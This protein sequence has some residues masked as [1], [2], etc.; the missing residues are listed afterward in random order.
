M[1]DK[2]DNTV[3]P[4]AEPEVDL[5]LNTDFPRTHGDSTRRLA[6]AMQRYA[7]WPAIGVAVIGIAVCTVLFGPHGG[8]AALIGGLVACGSSLGTLWLMRRAADLSPQVAMVVALGGFVGKLV[9]LMIVMLVLREV[10]WLHTKSLAFTMLA[11]VLVWAAAEA[12][13]FRR[14][15]IPTLILDEQK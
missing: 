12:V 11:T 14:T 7:L 3:E 9:I 8:V 6:A 1:T 5:G 13:A 10:T 15:K 2:T 4:D